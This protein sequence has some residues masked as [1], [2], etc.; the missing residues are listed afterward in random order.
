MSTV[1]SVCNHKGGVGKTT[2]T[3]NI[4]FSLSRYYKS[5]LI[6]IDPQCNLSSGLGICNKVSIGS[7]LKEIIHL[8]S[9]DVI[10]VKINNY[11]HIITGS[12]D[13][14]EIENVLHN[15]AGGDMLLKKIIDQVKNKYDLIL[16][17]CPP[18][19]NLL[20]LNALNSSDLIIIPAKPE[21]FSIDGIRQIENFACENHIPFKIIFNQVNTR[22]LHHQQIMS[23]ISG[24]FNGNTFKNSVRNTI[25]LAEAF[26]H[27]QDIFHYK[28]ESIG[29]KDFVCVADE[30]IDYI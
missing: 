9:P 12:L 26:G 15:T 5:L 24:K 17:D 29:A 18:S 19:Y 7:Y 16:I 13:L 11:V 22:S 21:K 10:P 28:N 3:A 6:D 2:L 25:S 1:I 27:A 20:T 4:G 23:I 30:L 8:G 14:I